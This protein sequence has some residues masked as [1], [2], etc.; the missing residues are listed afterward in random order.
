MLK[1]FPFK[2]SNRFAFERVYR[3][4]SRLDS[5]PR[6][7]SVSIEDLNVPRMELPANEVCSGSL[8]QCLLHDDCRGHVTY[9][10]STGAYVL[11][12][13]C[14]AMTVNASDKRG[15]ATLAITSGSI[16][17]AE[18][19]ERIVATLDGKSGLFRRLGLGFK[20]VFC[21]RGI[22][23]PVWG[24]NELDVYAPRHVY[25]RMLTAGLRESEDGLRSTRI[26][27]KRNTSFK[28]A[29]LIRPPTMTVESVQPVRVLPWDRG[30]IGVHI[31]LCEPLHLD[32][33][34]DEV[35]LYFVSGNEAVTEVKRAMQEFAGGKFSVESV[36]LQYKASTPL[37]H[38]GTNDDYMLPT[39]LCLSNLV[40][41][42]TSLHTLCRVK[43]T[44]L[45]EL[46]QELD[47]NI[48]YHSS[49]FV[50]KSIRAMNSIIDSHLSIPKY[51][52][53][54]RQLKSVFATNRC[55][56][57]FISRYS[58]DITPEVTLGVPP[59]RVIMELTSLMT[60]HSLDSAKRT[61]T[62][63]ETDV[64][65]LLSDSAPP[66]IRMFRTVD[67]KLAYKGS[68][69]SI[70]YTTSIGDLEE[71]S[72][73][74]RVQVVYSVIHQSFK[75]ANR[76]F[77]EA[78]V[79]YLARSIAALPFEPHRAPLISKSS[80]PTF[81]SS[82]KADF[83]S[84]VMVESVATGLNAI[85]TTSMQRECSYGESMYTSIFLGIH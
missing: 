50:S 11:P 72:M 34:G 77:E 29:L 54:S 79:L 4:G 71:L 25:D 21:C 70:V 55:Y 59:V 39:T 69:K 1:Y 43:R 81:L 64:S 60:Q 13:A 24:P 61:S 73:D 17:K 48:P 41:S 47:S 26:A 32:F 8:N 80:G 27:R 30:C 7:T 85:S 46:E 33:D 62:V 22:A 28:Y 45:L 36:R 3:L 42:L 38:L 5:A 76:R 74:R 31:S 12:N 14:T 20:P 49:T 23:V 83:L 58:P 2:M 53:T 44:P 66:H 57:N 18:Y 67:G 10:S 15:L 6:I 9:L 68:T 19:A 78:D 75:E 52:E 63:T 82:V 56:K 65:R 37:R 40:A 51:H 16:T 35:H 84:I